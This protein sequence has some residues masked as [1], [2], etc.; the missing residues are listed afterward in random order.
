MIKKTIILF[1]IL[2]L[3]H[4]VFA[5]ED[6]IITA[7]G[8]LS[9]IKIQHNDIVDVFPLITVTNDKNTL[10]VHP[11]KAGSTKFTV[12][13]D[14]KDKFLFSVNVTDKKTN[15]SEV[16]GFEIL[17]FDC[18][19]D[20]YEYSFELDKPPVTEQEIKKETDLNNI[21]MDIDEPPFFYNSNDA[22][23]NKRINEAK[24]YQNFIDTLSEPPE[25][26]GE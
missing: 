18:P 2:I 10:F 5:Y 8:K 4:S 26:R 9:D 25:L 22:E 12:L 6:C 19:P 15:I 21:E 7:D 13:K 11:L 17:T 14:K 24:E 20:V 3:S 16:K 23:V 1:C